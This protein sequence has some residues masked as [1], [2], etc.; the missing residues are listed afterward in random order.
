M[1]RFKERNDDVKCDLLIMFDVILKNSVE[2][3]QESIE[4]DLTHKISVAKKKSYTDLMVDGAASVME[5][6]QKLLKHKHLRI[7]IQAL[8]T[9]S[10]LALVIQFAID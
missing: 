9:L 6:I 2:V 4:K 10:N 1:E 8:T 3:G 7:R 5:E